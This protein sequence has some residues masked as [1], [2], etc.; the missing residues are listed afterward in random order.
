MIK[1]SPEDAALLKMNELQ[2]AAKCLRNGGA[3]DMAGVC[4]RADAKIRAQAA[5][6]ERL[7]EV[8]EPFKAAAEDIPDDKP[9]SMHAEK[10]LSSGVPLTVGDLRR[11]KAA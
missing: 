10:A 5:E 9:N 2:I 6:I 1:L 11:A 3:P 4:D 8:L 7:R